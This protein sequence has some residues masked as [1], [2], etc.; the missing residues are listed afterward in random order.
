LLA[1]GLA[2][3]QSFFQLVFVLLLDEQLLLFLVFVLLFVVVDLE[4]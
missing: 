1:F 2:G 4:L 3:P